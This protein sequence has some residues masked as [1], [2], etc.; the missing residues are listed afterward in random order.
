MKELTEHIIEKIEKELSPQMIISEPVYPKNKWDSHTAIEFRKDW[1]Y[2]GNI[3][4][5]G[6]NN[7]N[8][9][10]FHISQITYNRGIPM[11]RV[12][13]FSVHAYKPF[14]LQN[15]MQEIMSV[16]EDFKHVKI[17]RIEKKE[18]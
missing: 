7:P 12:H 15:R 17:E 16:V 9:L 8:H 4:I 13:N 3:S 6:S 18:T 14:E 5:S 2:L 11:N 1:M 10:N